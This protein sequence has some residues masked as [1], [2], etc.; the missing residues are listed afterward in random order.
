MTLLVRLAQSASLILLTGLAWAEPGSVPPGLAAVFGHDDD[1]AYR[2]P[3]G[4]AVSFAI[5][6][7]YGSRLSHRGP[8]YFT[9]DFGM[10]E[11]TQVYSAREG[12]VLATEDRFDISCWAADCDRYA[13]FVEI[14]HAD[15]TVGRYFH[16]QQGSVIVRPGQRVA[17]GEAI[18]RSGDTG[19]ATVPH[20]HFGVYRVSGAGEARSIA[21]RFAARDGLVL[22]PRA[23][24]RYI[25]ATEEQVAGL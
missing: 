20:L 7:S 13:N 19:L 14:L 23:G 16:L 6:Q 24:A 15:G 2:L 10:P 1:Y 11:G 3:Y 22:R 5:L 21:V 4:D 25:N 9:L 8:E 18:A 17:R 12:T